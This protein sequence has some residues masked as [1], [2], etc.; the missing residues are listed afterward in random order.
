M[1]PVERSRTSVRLNLVSELQNL[2]LRRGG[3]RSAKA[4]LLSQNQTAVRVGRLRCGV[5]SPAASRT[6]EELKPELVDR[7]SARRPVRGSQ[8][9]RI[10]PCFQLGNGDIEGEYTRI[11]DLDFAGGL[12]HG[13]IEL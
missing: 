10:G 12:D 9:K 1:Q 6:N 13:S 11:R 7:T 5:V 4:L 2:A 3:C 8:F